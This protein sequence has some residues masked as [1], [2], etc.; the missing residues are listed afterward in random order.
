M[1]R[2]PDSGVS[3][4]KSVTWLTCDIAPEKQPTGLSPGEGRAEG[5]DQITGGFE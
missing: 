1:E 3:P 4:V 2:V 5:R